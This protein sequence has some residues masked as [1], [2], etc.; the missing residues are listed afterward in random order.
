MSDPLRPLLAVPVAELEASA[1]EPDWAEVRRKA[2]RLRARRLAL[3]IGM[4]ALSATLAVAAATPALGLQG[5]LFHL[6]T[7]GG[8]APARVVKDFAELDVGAPAGMA[9]GVVAGQAREVLSAP[10]ST[11]SRAVLWVAPTQSGGFCTALSPNG[12]GS[13]GGGC[14]RDRL[15]RFAP[16]LLIPGPISREGTIRKPPVLI[17]GHTLLA[18]AAQ[19]EVRFQDGSRARTPVVWV[20]KPI[21]AGFFIYEV[22]PTQWQPGHRSG[23]LI[24]EDASGREL[25]RAKSPF[26]DVVGAMSMVD[27]ETGA[28]RWRSPRSGGC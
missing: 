13:G 3:R 2:R 25:A 4:L 22:P 21:N 5:R 16:E 8:P 14:D 19:V 7:A 28:P 18:G 11:G 23:E 1:S 9:P 17:S 6:F 15:G 24:L 20:G 27:P 10:L 12:S 26:D